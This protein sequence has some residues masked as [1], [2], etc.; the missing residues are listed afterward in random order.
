MAKPFYPQDD[1]PQ[2]LFLKN[3]GVTFLWL[4]ICFNLLC[5][6]VFFGHD[7]DALAGVKCSQEKC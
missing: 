6:R 3:V 4:P 5:E 2:H 7:F 1:L